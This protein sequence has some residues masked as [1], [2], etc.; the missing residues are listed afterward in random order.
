MQPTLDSGAFIYIKT[1]RTAFFRRTEMGR[2]E[3]MRTEDIPAI[4]FSEV[5][6]HCD[7]LVSVASISTDPEWIDRGTDAHHPSS[8]E[9]EAENYWYSSSTSDLGGSAKIRREALERIVSRLKIAG[10]LTLTEKHLHVRG[11]QTRLPH[12]YRFSG[13]SS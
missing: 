11:C 8:W 12:P 10:K 13:G 9:R 6:R 5:M 1:D 2:G 3:P 7:L 4:V